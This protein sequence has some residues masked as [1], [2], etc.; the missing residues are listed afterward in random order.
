MVKAKMEA[1]AKKHYSYELSDAQRP[2][3]RWKYYQEIIKIQ[4][5]TNTI[6]VSLGQLHTN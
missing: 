6:C 4:F 2:T 3:S 5:K 1:T